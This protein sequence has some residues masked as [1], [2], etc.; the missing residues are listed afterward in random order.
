MPMMNEKI[1]NITMSTPK[2]NRKL[3][4]RFIDDVGR[5]VMTVEGI[6]DL[7]SKGTDISGMIVE[8]CEETRKYNQFTNN[9]LILYTD[10]MQA[11]SAHEYNT[12]AS[13]N[14]H[15]PKEFTSIDVKEWLFNRCSTDIEQHRVI[16]E[17]NMYNERNLYPLL[18]HLI[19][20]VDHFR[21]NNVVWGVGR[22]SSVASYVLYLIGIHKIDSIKY[23]LEISEFLR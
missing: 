2:L 20:L 1:N 13:S 14:W 7:I 19:F 5:T 22:G 3:T 12:L 6:F 9:A 18:Y 16:Q 15:T 21:K 4:G 17:L 11:Q 8:D 23:N 10:E